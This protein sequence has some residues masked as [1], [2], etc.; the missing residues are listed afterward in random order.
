MEE[1]NDKEAAMLATLIYIPNIGGVWSE[2]K[3]AV[4]LKS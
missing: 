1:I 2:K 4:R 3:K